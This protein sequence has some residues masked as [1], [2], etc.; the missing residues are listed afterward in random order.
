V[1]DLAGGTG[2]SSHVKWC[3]TGDGG[4]QA[5]ALPA[6]IGVIDASIHP[7]GVKTQGVGQHRQAHPITVVENQQATRTGCQY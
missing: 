3:A 5:S 7:L 6:S 2:A 4:P 1:I